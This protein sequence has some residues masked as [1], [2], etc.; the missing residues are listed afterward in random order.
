MNKEEYNQEKA[1]IDTLGLTLCFAG[2]NPYPIVNDKYEKL[3]K[4]KKKLAEE[5]LK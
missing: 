2:I 1:K 4:L 3:E 5:E